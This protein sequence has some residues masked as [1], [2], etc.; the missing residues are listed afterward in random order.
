MLHSLRSERLIVA[1]DANAQSSLW[2][3]LETDKRGRKFEILIHAFSLEV[4]NEV[5]QGS[6][7]ETRRESSFIDVS[8]DVP[9]NKL[10][11]L[12][13]ARMNDQ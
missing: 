6:T 8:P 10:I 7:F 11:D 1:V 2:G 4:I 3:S 13:E 9:S 12:D 5:H